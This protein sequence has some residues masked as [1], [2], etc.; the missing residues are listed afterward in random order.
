M[1]EQGGP[2]IY[3]LTPEKT[4]EVLSTL[5]ATIPIQKLP[6]DIENRTIPDGPDG[7][8]IPIIIVRLQIAAMKFYPLLYTFMVVDGYLVDLI[9]TRDW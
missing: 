9:P 8:D 7:K 3:T 5:Q 4:R 1:Q 2:P 6:A